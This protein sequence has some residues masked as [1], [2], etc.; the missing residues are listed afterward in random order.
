MLKTLRKNTKVI[1]WGIIVAFGMWGAFS[2]STQFRD[3]GQIAGRV[4]GSPVSYQEFNK[5]RKATEIFSLTGER[6]EDP[7]IL[8]QLTWQNIIFAREAKRLHIKV[9]DDEVR[10]QV[11]KLLDAQKVPAS[12]PE[13]YERWVRSISS[14]SPREFEEM[15]R[16]MIRVQKLLKE[17]RA[18]PVTEPTLEEAKKSFLLEKRKLELEVLRFP[19][20]DAAKAFKPE[21]FKSP[22]VEKPG[23]L[24]LR[25]LML[26]YALTEA[27]VAALYALEPQAVSEP[28]P[29]GSNAFIFRLLSKNSVSEADFDTLGTGDQYRKELL[30]RK[31]MEHFMDW[32]LDLIQRSHFQDMMPGG[33]S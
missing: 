12:S 1:I 8:H 9:S 17:M 20:L 15:I 3:Q 5:L 13:I 2:V 22:A 6:M 18:A 4:F 11:Q 30:N 7:G 16:E 14:A 28:L 10:A 24:G 31:R 25:D 26:N 23:S 32:H 33:K 21:M 29:A 27:H 19:D